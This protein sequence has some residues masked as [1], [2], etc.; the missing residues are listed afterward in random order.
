MGLLL[1]SSSSSRGCKLPAVPSASP[2]GSSND[3]KKLDLNSI[4]CEQ[5]ATGRERGELGDSGQ[6]WPRVLITRAVCS[7][8]ADTRRSW[9]APGQDRLH[10][11]ALG[12]L[13]R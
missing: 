13:Q 9:E 6:V 4:R 11:W 2:D 7:D 10:G 8:K 12:W 3:D 1:C 5:G